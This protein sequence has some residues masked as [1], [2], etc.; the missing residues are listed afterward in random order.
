MEEAGK[1]YLEAAMLLETADNRPDAMACRRNAARMWIKLANRLRTGDHHE[2]ER[3]NEILRRAS[4]QLALVQKYWED[5]G[6]FRSARG[7]LKDRARHC[8]TLKNYEQASDLYLLGARRLCEGRVRRVN[9]FLILCTSCLLVHGSIDRARETFNRVVQNRK[10]YTWK[11]KKPK[12]WPDDCWIP[13]VMCDVYLMEGDI[14]D[15]QASWRLTIDRVIRQ[16]GPSTEPLKALKVFLSPLLT[17]HRLT[18]Y[19]LYY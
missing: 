4:V 8:R 3:S 11:G 12:E 16:Q 19:A 2:E 13:F 7:I 6:D 9:K 14:M 1:A 15:L 10:L 5:E 18:L 17:S